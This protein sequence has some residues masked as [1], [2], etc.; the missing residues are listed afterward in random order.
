MEENK[1][2]LKLEEYINLIK[3]NEALKIALENKENN[4][5]AL[6]KYAKE[7]VKSSANYHLRNLEKDFDLGNKLIS[8]LKDYNYK[9]IVDDF[10]ITGIGY[11]LIEQLTDELI[12]ESREKTDE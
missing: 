12:I 2:V 6:C 11:D 4:Y 1:V 7:Q 10:I 5:I 9:N 8:K 3:E